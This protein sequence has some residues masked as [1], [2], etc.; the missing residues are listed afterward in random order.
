MQEILF[1]FLNHTKLPM[2]KPIPFYMSEIKY[3]SKKQTEAMQKKLSKL[4]MRL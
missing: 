2:E 1:L 3:S 4:L